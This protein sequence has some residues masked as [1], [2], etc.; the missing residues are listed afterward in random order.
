MWIP[1]P[2][3]PEAERTPLVQQLLDVIVLQQERIQQLEEQV[4][5]QQERIQQLE[6]EIARL[7]GLKTR[8]RI[9]PSVLETPRR[10]PR[11]PNAK[12]PGSAK[13]S[14]TAQLTIT[15]ETVI[16]LPRV[17]EGSVFKGYE[18]FVVQD[19]VLKPRVI[20]YR[21]E[22]WLTP[23]GQSLVAP[24]PADVVP[25]SHYG[26]DL[27]CFILHQYHHQH[28]TQPLLWEQ[29][30]Q[31]GIDISAGELSRI[32]TEGKDAFHQEKDE[33][34]PAALAVSAYVQV[35][36]TGARHQGHN[37]AC[38]QIGN[39]LFA[40]FASTDSKSRLNFLEILRRPYAD[41]VINE[42]AVAYWQRQKLPKAVMDQ[43]GPGPETFADPAAWQSRLRQLGI[44]QPRHTRIASEGALLGSLIAHGVSPELTILSDGAGQYDVLV[45]AACWIHAERP[46]ARLIPYSEKH[47]AA[48]E[49]VRG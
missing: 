42:T 24:L 30:H 2:E 46:L 18:D 6:D 3:I 49:A 48:I 39:E 40:F 38:T 35:D 14:K 12:R 13:R 27:I 36:D 29:L 31:L 28:V 32:L 4:C 21:R 17:P 23:E 25:G 11:D 43:L 16:P 10:P 47:R 34:L 15:E 45:H 44:T 41:Y 9:A 19:L 8:P 20:R 33:L 37:G 7:K 1:L 5:M 22:R 26:P